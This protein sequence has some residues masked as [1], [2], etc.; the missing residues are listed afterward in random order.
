MNSS[1]GFTGGIFLIVTFAV[2]GILVFP[3]YWMLQSSA[4]PGQSLFQYPPP[5]WPSEWDFSAYVEVFRDTDLGIWMKNS[6][7]VSITSTLAALIIGTPGAFALSRFRYRG[8]QALAFSILITQMMP[9][10]V[11]MFPMFRIFVALGWIDSLMALIFANFAFSLPV[12]VWLMKSIFDSIPAEIE[13]AARV[14]GAS[15][16]TILFRIT[17]PLALPGFAA[18]GIYAFIDTWEEYMLARTI[19]TSS[20]N[21]VASIGIASFVGQYTTDWSQIMAAA[22]IFSLPPAILFLLIQKNFIAGLSAGAVKG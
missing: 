5:L 3:F 22:V 2:C 10:L 21:W 17:G 18:T 6:L 19:V 13:E 20:E 8:K 11:L 14:E 15:W 16:L 7:I 12:V 9:I 4:V 1:K